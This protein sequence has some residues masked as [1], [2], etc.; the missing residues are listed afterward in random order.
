[1]RQP[2]VSSLEESPGS[3]E[4]KS[5]SPAGSK[6]RRPDGSKSRQPLSEWDRSPAG[7]E[8]S[9]EVDRSQLGRSQLSLE[10]VSLAWKES[11]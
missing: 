9:L 6:S 8:V 7:G 5:R 1:V 4:V 2:P 11:A 10:G 3:L